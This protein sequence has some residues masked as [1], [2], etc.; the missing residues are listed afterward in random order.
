MKRDYKRDSKLVDQI[1][2]QQEVMTLYLDLFRNL[3]HGLLDCQVEDVYELYCEGEITEDDLKEPHNLTKLLL[4]FLQYL[5]NELKADF[6]K[7]EE[8]LEQY[9]YV[10]ECRDGTFG[11]KMAEA[12]TTFNKYLICEQYGW[13]ITPNELFDYENRME[14]SANRQEEVQ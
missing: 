13:Y 1:M 10:F 12:Q 7:C 8:Q 5:R 14:Q 4:S 11:L 9:N 3:P 2:C 6:E